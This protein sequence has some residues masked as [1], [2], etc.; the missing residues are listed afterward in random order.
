MYSSYSEPGIELTELKSTEEVYNH[1]NLSDYESARGL[2]ANLMIWPTNA[3]DKVFIRK[4]D[5][6]PKYCKGETFRYTIEGWGLIQL[7][8]SGTNQMGLFYSTTTHNSETRVKAFENDSSNK[9]GKSTDWDWKEVNR[10]SRKIINF[11]KKQSPKKVGPQPVMNC[12]STITIA[13]GNEK[14]K[15][16]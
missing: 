8:L 16:V 5:L 3:S 2:K 12:A 9:S 10:V 6:D 4:V 11:I 1:F 7:Q 13:G 15:K 14:Y